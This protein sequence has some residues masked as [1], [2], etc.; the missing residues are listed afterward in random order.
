MT[1]LCRFLR[2]GGFLSAPFIYNLRRFFDFCLGKKPLCDYTFHMAKCKY[3]HRSIERFDSDICP[4][5]GNKKPLEEGYKTMDITQTFDSFRQEGA[6]YKSK[7]KKTALILGG[8]LGAFGAQWFYLGFIKKGIAECLVS[9]FSTLAIGF[10][11]FFTFLPN[12]FAF[13]IPFAINV[14]VGI[15][16]MILLAIDVSPKDSNGELLR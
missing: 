4:Y 12:A 13:V 5:C 2:G 7:S 10:L 8:F 16:F 11:F 15:I 6:L 9:V 14:I 3:C 1:S